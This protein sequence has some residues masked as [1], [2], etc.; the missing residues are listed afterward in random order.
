MGSQRQF[1]GPEPSPGVLKGQITET[2]QREIRGKLFEHCNTENDA[3]KDQA[4]NIYRLVI[5]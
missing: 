3:S 2:I 5:T 4:L 1:V